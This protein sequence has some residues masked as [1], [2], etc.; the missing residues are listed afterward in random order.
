MGGI[1]KVAELQIKQNQTHSLKN[2]EGSIFAWLFVCL[3]VWLVVRQAGD[4]SDVT[5][6]FEDAQV[7]QTLM[8]DE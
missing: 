4:T 8:D 6:S 7:F 1:T 3:V 5:L 2:L